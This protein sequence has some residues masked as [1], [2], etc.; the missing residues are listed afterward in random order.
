MP[1]LFDIGKSGLQA[2]R[3]SL[4]VTGQNIANINTDGYKKRE[5]SLEEVTGAGGGVTEISDQTGLGVRVENIK[6]AFD[7]FL[8][9]KVRQTSALHQKADSYLDEVKSLEN[10]LL[11]SEANLSNSI[12]EFFG[13]LQQIAA[14]PDDQAPRIIAIEKGKDLAG[15]FN[16][17]SDRI[18]R[19]KDQIFKKS[20]N[21]VT[22]VNLLSE[23]ISA[24]NAKLLASG[25]AGDSSNALLD[26]RDLL[27][28]QLSEVSQITVTYINKGAAEIRAWKYRLRSCNC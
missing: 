22:S 15:Q 23:Q 14:A 27:I 4:A 12:G 17:Y 20:E 21:A 7:E 6:R 9:D 26:Q 18:E 19:L 11:P 24:I 5:A 25:G 16:L 1:S 13:S 2:Y 28:D 3:Q 8:I 10:L